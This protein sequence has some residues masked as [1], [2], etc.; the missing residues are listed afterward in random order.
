MVDM[1]IFGCVCTMALYTVEFKWWCFNVMLQVQQIVICQ[2]NR[3]FMRWEM[4]ISQ[5]RLRD[6]EIEHAV[7]PYHLCMKYIDI[8]PLS[9]AVNY[10]ILLQSI[11]FDVYIYIL[12]IFIDYYSI[13]INP[14]GSNIH[15][16]RNR[17]RS[18][19]KPFIATPT[20]PS[21]A[22]SRSPN[23]WPKNW[24]TPGKIWLLLC[25]FLVLLPVVEFMQCKICYLNET[26]YINI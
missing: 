23:Q 21:P 9:I 19:C 26:V 22:T 4:L 6:V 7:R 3:H 17:F 13:A 15:S 12:F 5:P 18:R 2:I 1:V 11:Y 16:S 10:I 24:G 25:F 14:H 8:L 20:G